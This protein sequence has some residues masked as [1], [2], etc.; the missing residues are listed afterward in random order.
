MFWV[1]KVTHLLMTFWRKVELLKYCTYAQSKFAWT[2]PYSIYKWWTVS[3]IKLFFDSQS[4][5]ISWVNISWSAYLD[6]NFIYICGFP[7]RKVTKSLVYRESLLITVILDFLV[8]IKSYG[9]DLG[10][11]YSGCTRDAIRSASSSVCVI[12]P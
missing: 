7:R 3:V 4:N 2:M 5:S 9:Y 10:T 12:V 11:I 6:G 8:N 1:K